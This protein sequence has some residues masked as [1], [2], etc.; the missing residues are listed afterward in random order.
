MTQ[1]NTEKETC[2]DGNALPAESTI[3]RNCS[4]VPG[5]VSTVKLGMAV[6]MN[7]NTSSAISVMAAQPNEKRSSSRRSLASSTG[8]AM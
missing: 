6:G 8:N 7:Q 3:F 4:E 5:V 2:S 1:A